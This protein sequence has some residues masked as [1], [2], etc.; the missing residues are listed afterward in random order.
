[1]VLIEMISSCYI[2]GFGQAETV[3]VGD[4]SVE[5]EDLMSKKASAF[6]SLYIS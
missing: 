6:K 3:H 2:R 1:M 5:T 4:E